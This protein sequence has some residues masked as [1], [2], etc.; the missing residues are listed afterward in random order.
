M[1]EALAR[2]AAAR[3]ATAEEL[4]AA[5]AALAAAARE[6]RELDSDAM[7]PLGSTCSAFGS[8]WWKW[9]VAWGDITFK[10]LSTS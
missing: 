10:V 1:R 8:L 6:V 2:R 9:K 5:E 7:A 4:R 3:R